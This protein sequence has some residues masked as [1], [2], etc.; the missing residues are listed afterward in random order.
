M[1]PH[2]GRIAGVL[3]FLAAIAAGVVWQF[4]PHSS[5]ANQPGSM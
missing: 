3:I 4:R 2:L 5:T 1:K